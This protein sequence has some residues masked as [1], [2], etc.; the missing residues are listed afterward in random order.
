MDTDLHFIGSYIW[1]WLNDG[2][3]SFV[4]GAISFLTFFFILSPKIK[5]A[6]LTY[7]P[8]PS[9]VFSDEYP[10]QYKIGIINRSAHILGICGHTIYNI[11]IRARLTVRTSQKRTLYFDI[12]VDN[13][14]NLLIPALPVTKKNPVTKKYP[15]RW[16]TLCYRNPRGLGKKQMQELG[17]PEEYS[18]RD[19]LNIQ[20]AYLTIYISG[21]GQFTGQEKDFEVTYLASDIQE[22][23][24]TNSA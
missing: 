11:S 12:R 4:G 21:R 14:Q 20:G 1:G 2:L 15:Y 24:R 6:P 16:Y 19:L 22:M 17:L 10:T 5:F 8:S 13:E 7:D 23:K 18:L 3:P 9:N